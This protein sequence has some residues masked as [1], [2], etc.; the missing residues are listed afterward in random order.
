[1]EAWTQDGHI[2][3]FS[4][5][6]WK[7]R[8]LHEIFKFI[9]VASNWIGQRNHVCR[10]CRLPNFRFLQR[11]NFISFPY[12]GPINLAFDSPLSSLIGGSGV[13]TEA[14]EEP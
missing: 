10:V 8:F 6:R 14:R 4:N 11:Y 2:F 5:S 1:M 3:L 13:G 7:C 12:H 9:N